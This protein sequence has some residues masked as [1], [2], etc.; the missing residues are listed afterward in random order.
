MRP[1]EIKKPSDLAFP[2]AENGGGKMQ[3]YPIAV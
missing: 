1:T 2:A 3:K